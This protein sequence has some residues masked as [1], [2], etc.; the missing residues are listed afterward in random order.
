MIGKNPR[1]E[2]KA[3][4]G[5]LLAL[6]LASNSFSSSPLMGADRVPAGL[7]LDKLVEKREQSHERVRL[8]NVKVDNLKASSEIKGKAQVDALKELSNIAIEEKDVDLQKGLVGL[9]KLF[10]EQDRLPKADY[11][12]LVKEKFVLFAEL[13]R[14]IQQQKKAAAEEGKKVPVG[15]ALAATIPSA[16]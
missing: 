5:P 1:M 15:A 16:R 3:V 6:L 13:M 8:F 2:S 9:A 11:D 12:K 4:S 10:I 14:L 7:E